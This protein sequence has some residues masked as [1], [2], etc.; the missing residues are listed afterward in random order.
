MRL[1]AVALLAAVGAG[2]LHEPFDALLQ[3]Y[4]DEQGRVAYRDLAV[5]D[6][7]TL[8]A[9]L[10][11][12]ATANPDALSQPEQ[13]AFWLNAYNAH[14]LRG[15]LDG[16][17]AEGFFGR[18]RFFSFYDF[19]VAGTTRTLDDIENGILRARF[20]EPRIHF[21]LVCAS[22]SCPKL[23][24]E[25]Y[26]GERL[27]AQLDDQARGFLSD[28][29]RNQFGPG[30]SARVSMIFKW[31]QGDFDAAAGSVPAFIGRW[32]PVQFK[33]LSYLDYDWTMNAQPGQ[34]PQ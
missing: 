21:A 20:H 2:D 34:R 18:K 3:R 31:F 30:E 11:S 10:Q 9:Y 27:D 22:T 29:T 15:V 12:L 16:Y 14:V 24:R 19:P 8:D 1:L 6:G 4:V 32:V 5:R 26:R 25:A 17:S 23:R 7:A 28:R 13:I 33:T